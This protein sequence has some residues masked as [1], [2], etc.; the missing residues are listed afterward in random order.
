MYL[1]IYIDIYA[2]FEVQ[3]SLQQWRINKTFNQLQSKPFDTLEICIVVWTYSEEGL[4]VCVCLRNKHTHK[5]LM[6][7]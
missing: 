4:R 2:F 5:Q 3:R 7:T 1:Y 6:P